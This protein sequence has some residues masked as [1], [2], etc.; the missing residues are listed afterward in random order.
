[1]PASTM[2]CFVCCA[3]V[4]AAMYVSSGV[5]VACNYHGADRSVVVDIDDHYV[6]FTLHDLV[7]M[8]QA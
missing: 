7:V 5:I 8:L 3:D 4:G 1:M 6:G 2:I